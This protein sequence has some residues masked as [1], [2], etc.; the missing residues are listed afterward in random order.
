M[1][2]AAVAALIVL[3]TTTLCADHPRKEV[4][5]RHATSFAVSDRPVT[6]TLA[7][8]RSSKKVK[9]AAKSAATM[10]VL[11]VEGVTAEKAPGFL[12]A[13]FVGRER[14][15]EVSLYARDQPQTFSFDA[16]EAIA[17]MPR[18]GELTVRFV[19]ESGLDGQPARPE[20]PVRIGAVSLTIER[21]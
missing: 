13:V 6:V 7:L 4:V 9:A 20:A 5:A 16:D 1:L 14:V 18:R 12:V 15:G 17:K 11:H 21:Q 8:G 3:N 2:R 10:V 19:P